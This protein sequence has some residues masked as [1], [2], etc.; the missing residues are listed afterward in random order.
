MNSR[1]ILF[2][3]CLVIVIIGA[4]NWGLVALDEKND[5]IRCLF[6]NQRMIQSL[7]YACV[8]IAGIVASYIWL[9]FPND[10]CIIIPNTTTLST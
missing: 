9:S 6:P 5:L 10:V 1:R 2:Q 4:I 3:I 8:G 7:I